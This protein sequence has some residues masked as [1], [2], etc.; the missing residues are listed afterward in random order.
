MTTPLTPEHKR[1][2]DAI[3][4]DHRRGTPLTWW[5][6]KLGMTRGTLNHRLNGR[7]PWS[8]DDALRI[9]WR[10][11][12]TVDSLT[13]GQWAEAVAREDNRITA[14]QAANIVPGTYTDDDG[15]T[16]HEEAVAVFGQPMTMEAQR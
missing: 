8:L 6:R 13:N 5:A 7:T 11:G 14:E 1:I 3:R 15:P 4:D 9:A 10:L 12:T 2:T 16:Y